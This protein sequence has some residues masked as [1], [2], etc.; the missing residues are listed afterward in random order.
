MLLEGSDIPEDDHSGRRLHLEAKPRDLP[1]LGDAELDMLGC[2]NGVNT[3]L[4][5]ALYHVVFRSSAAVAC[6]LACVQWWGWVLLK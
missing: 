6:M 1:E 5:A 4:Q 3:C 2:F